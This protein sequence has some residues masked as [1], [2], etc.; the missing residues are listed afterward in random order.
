MRTD[1]IAVGASVNEYRLTKER[2]LVHFPELEE[3]NQALMDTLEGITNIHEQIIALMRSADNDR[4]LVMGIKERI[5]ELGERMNRLESR[6]DTK[7]ELIASAMAAADLKKIEAP[8]WTISLRRIPPSVVIQNEDEIPEQFKK[9]RTLVSVD[10][11]A[12]KAALEAG[13]ILGAVMSN[14]GIGLSVRLK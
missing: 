8:E 6:H 14:G 7:R 2:L 9:T 5:A 11:A 4:I 10:K 12:L 1:S 13:P 3:D